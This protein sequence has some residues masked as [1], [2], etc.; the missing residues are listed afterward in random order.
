MISRDRIGAA[1]PLNGGRLRSDPSSGCAAPPT[2]PAR[3]V[4][5]MPR[6]SGLDVPVL[7]YVWRGLGLT[8]STEFRRVP[9]TRFSLIDFER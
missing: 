6:E 8:G 9:E 7:K 5:D 4:N 2:T 1:C 3:N